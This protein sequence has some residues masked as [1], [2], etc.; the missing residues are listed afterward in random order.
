MSEKTVYEHQTPLVSVYGRD[1]PDAAK[2]GVGAQTIEQIR[3][4]AEKRR[5]LKPGVYGNR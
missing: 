4:A 2:F 3:D 5:D 1:A